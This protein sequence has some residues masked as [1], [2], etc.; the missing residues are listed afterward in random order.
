MIKEAL[1][2]LK[3]ELKNLFK[4]KRTVFSTFILPLFILPVIFLGM[5]SVLDSMEK[6]AQQTS[7]ALDIRG[8]YDPVLDNLLDEHLQWYPASQATA[9]ISIVFPTTYAQGD[10]SDV[11]VTYDSS[12]KKTQWAVDTLERVLGLYELLIANNLLAEYGLSYDDIHT[13]DI[14]LEDT[15]AVQA[16]SATSMLAMLLPYFLVIFLFAGSMNAGLDTTSGEKERGSL[17]ILLVNQ[18]SRTS[19]AWGKIVYVSVV[20][21]TSAL[22]TYLGLVITMFVPIG[23]ATFSL[24]GITSAEVSIASMVV[25]II[26]LLSTALLTATVITLVGCLS[27][28]VKEGSSYVM[29]LYMLVILVGVVTMYMDPSTNILLFMIPI[30]N[31]IFIMKEA[32][33]GMVVIHHVIIA[34]ISH[35]VIAALGSMGVAKLFNS[36]RI[37]Q[38]V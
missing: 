16:R 32:L 2:I 27:K 17:A 33:L 25:I 9:K 3:K 31:T 23:A 13:L 22:A 7:Y 19:I 28:T 8:N 5:G 29:P 18:V 1:I 6:D 15:A 12:S 24:D 21:L 35:I 38:T 14:V 30:V 20:A 4:D 36:E 11:I 34:V 26:T 37:L 10:Q